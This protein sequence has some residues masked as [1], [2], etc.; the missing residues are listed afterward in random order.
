MASACHRTGVMRDSPIRI[1]AVPK[2]Y[3][4]PKWHAGAIIVG[5]RSA[6]LNSSLLLKF[7]GFFTTIFV[8]ARILAATGALRTS[9]ATPTATPARCTREK[10]D[11]VF[12]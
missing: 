9:L 5:P 4:E 1:K 11:H 6:A 3:A 10:Q 2:R 7:N 12:R 8:P